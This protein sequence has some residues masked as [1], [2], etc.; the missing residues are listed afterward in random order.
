M[1][2][3]HNDKIIAYKHENVHIL[4]KGSC[5]ADDSKAAIKCTGSESVAKGD[6]NAMKEAVG[7]KGPVAVMFDA[8]S[9]F[10]TYKWVIG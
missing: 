2:F 6:E 4:Q 8:D 3:S 10:I 1:L 5:Q 9:N 7:E